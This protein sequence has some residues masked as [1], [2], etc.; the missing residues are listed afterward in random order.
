MIE[1]D[2]NGYPTKRSLQQLRQELESWRTDPERAARA[3]YAALAD[4]GPYGASGP[5]RVEVRG[6]V[7]DVY[8]YHTLGWSG[9]EDVIRTLQG[10]WLWGMLLQR[11]DRGGHYYFDPL[12]EVMARLGEREE[13]QP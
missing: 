4:H 1:W 7:C 12:D 3:F 6:E 9:C 11:Y 8:G 2:V 5:E 13:A 10:T